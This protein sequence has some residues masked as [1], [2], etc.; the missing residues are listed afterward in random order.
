MM[1]I[2]PAIDIIDGKA[3]RL[4]EGD[5]L[6]K[7]IYDDDPVAVAQKFFDSGFDRLH[8]VDLDG[9]KAGRVR[10][11]KVLESIASTTSLWIDFGGG[12]RTSEDVNYV[13]NAGARQCTIGSIAVAQP[14][15][16]FKWITNYGA[17]KFFVGADVR[18][19]TIRVSGWTEDSKLLWNTFFEK[20]IA[21]GINEFFCTDISK[22]GKMEGPA[23]DLYNCILIAF[24]KIDLF[25]SGGVTSMDD[26]RTLDDAGCKGAIVGKAIYEN[27][28]SLKELAQYHTSC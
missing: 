5:Y 14:E 9:A 8:L 24:P 11:L 23:I 6:Q 10:N 17:E 1:Q 7:K 21:L 18:N 19:E 3:V 16:F 12:V 22:D 28:I 2:I 26:I 4:T 13:L 27:L 25:A 20:M 15:L